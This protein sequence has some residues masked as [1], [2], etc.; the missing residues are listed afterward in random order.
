MVESNGRKILNKK[1]STT[2]KF[3]L[4]LIIL[5]LVVLV[6]LM[7]WQKFLGGAS[8]YSAVYLR[9]GDLYFGRL[10]QFP[11][12]GLKN[13]YTISVNQQDPQNPLSIQRFAN[14]FWGPQDY[15]KINRSEV[16][17]M[18]EL[19]QSGQ[20]AQLLKTNPQLVPSR[21]TEQLPPSSITPPPPSSNNSQPK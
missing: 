11:S 12:F 18:T 6:G 13:V 19:N 5:L 2:N 17:W 8:S 9:T 14:V 15:I 3:L 21:G 10:M 1:M 7:S 16:V 20:L 4:V